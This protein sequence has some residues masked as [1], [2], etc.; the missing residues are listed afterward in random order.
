VLSRPISVHITRVTARTVKWVSFALL[1]GLIGA[2][3]GFGRH[4]HQ[5]AAGNSTRLRFMSWALL[6]EQT[7]S[8][9]LSKLQFLLWAAVVAYCCVYFSMANVFVQGK[10]DVF[11][12]LPESFEWLIGVTGGTSL[13]T[14]LLSRSRASKGAGTAVPT[15]SDLITTGGVLAPDRVWCE[16]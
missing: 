11:P 14:T 3:M 16:R 15:V 10:F 1:V 8:Y 13:L 9:S 7:N 6:D 5:P 2:V 4:A 12:A